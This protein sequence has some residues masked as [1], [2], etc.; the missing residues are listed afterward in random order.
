MQIFHCIVLYC[1]TGGLS[2]GIPGEVRGYYEAWKKFG[3]LEWAALWQPTIQLLEN[4]F[5]VEKPPSEVI[6]R[7]EG[8]IRKDPNFRLGN[9]RVFLNLV[10]L[11][12]ILC[13]LR[14]RCK[15]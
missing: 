11:Y 9:V 2:V 3:R 1:I 5:K 10:P 14:G 8:V 13:L 6:A 4:G 12:D 7:Y 15:L